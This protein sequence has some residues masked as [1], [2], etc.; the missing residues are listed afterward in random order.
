MRE[1]H[2][3]SHTQLEEYVDEDK[4]NFGSN[5]PPIHFPGQNL[6]DGTYPIWMQTGN[7]VRLLMLA[8]QD[9]CIFYQFLFSSKGWRGPFGEHLIL[10]KGEGEGIM[11]S[12]FTA[13]ELGFGYALTNVQL[14][15]MNQNRLD[16]EYLSKEKG[17]LLRGSVEKQ[18]IMR[19]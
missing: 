2:V 7:G 18:P 10:P 17:I 15:T 9:G 8:G 1:Y 13:R 5:L 3:D 6:E 19:E 16:T 12:A 4:K 11:Y 14:Q